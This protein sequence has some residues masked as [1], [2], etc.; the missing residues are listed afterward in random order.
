MSPNPLTTTPLTDVDATIDGPF[1]DENE[2][3]IVGV[4]ARTVPG[5]AAVHLT[6][7]APDP[8]A[9]DPRAAPTTPR[10]ESTGARPERI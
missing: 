7:P 6:E 10:S 9:K 3:T 2:R 5:I 1:G 8:F 4:V